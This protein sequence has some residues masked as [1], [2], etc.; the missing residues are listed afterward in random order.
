MNL[1]HVRG[2][3]VRRGERILA[4]DLSFALA[5]PGLYFLTGPNGTG[6]STLLL[7]LAGLLPPARG[8]VLLAGSPLY[9][10][11]AMPKQMRARRMVYLPQHPNAPAELPALEL[12][13]L[14]RLPH[15]HWTQPP[16]EEDYR[17]AREA[18]ALVGFK[19]PPGQ[20]MGTL[21]GG[22]RQMVW[23]AQGLVQNGDL[24]L[25]DEPT[26]HLDAARR[27]YLFGLLRRL[28]AE[29]GKTLLVATHELDALAGLA[30]ARYL[31]MLHPEAGFMP[32]SP[33]ALAATLEAHKAA[34]GL[35]G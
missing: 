14:G 20:W 33:D 11:G 31:D 25:M 13:A 12:A 27:V 29:M 28:C 4:A 21:S 30:E 7:T 24:W 34:S 2:L 17:L 23:L 16:G 6:K 3:E 1:L 26:Q 22:E 19:R 10:D 9:G 15:L 35:F 32:C 5:G 8:Q 18:L